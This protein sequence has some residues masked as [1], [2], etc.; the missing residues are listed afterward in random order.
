MLWVSFSALTVLVGWQ[1]GHPAHE[2]ATYTQRFCS[3]TSGQRK[4]RVLSSPGWPGK[5][6]L[7][8]SWV[9]DNVRVSSIKWPWCL[10]WQWLNLC[11]DMRSLMNDAWSEASF[12]SLEGITITGC[13]RLRRIFTMR[14]QAPDTTDDDGGGPY[15]A[16]MKDDTVLLFAGH[17]LCFLCWTLMEQF[18]DSSRH[19]QSFKL[20]SLHGKYGVRAYNE[21]LR[22]ELP[23]GSWGRVPGHGGYRANALKPRTFS[24][25]ITNQEAKFATLSVFC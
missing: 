23:A 15:F 13:C 3:G 18:S 16:L 22:M 17:V 19:C 6:L 25:W 24:H 8:Q 9:D 12:G 2:K 10:L 4:L 14:R 5:E 7:I 20:G 21:G 11:V 1:E